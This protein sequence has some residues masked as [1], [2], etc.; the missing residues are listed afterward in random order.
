MAGRAHLRIPLETRFWAMVQKGD[1]C[2]TWTGARTPKGYGRFSVT[3]RRMVGAHR[4]AV[5]LS[6]REIPKAHDVCHHCD[7]P[8]CV[9][10][11]HLFVGTRS[12]NMYDASKKGRLSC[13]RG[14]R[15]R[16]THC[17]RGHEY[18][19]ESTGVNKQQGGRF[20]RICNRE[21]KRKRNQVRS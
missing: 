6:G 18:T 9:N 20:C 15:R 10:P 11:A 17:F 12:E 19:P 16:R 8:P 13:Q 2:W 7:N 3:S 14:S 5:L 1:G 4:V 21:A